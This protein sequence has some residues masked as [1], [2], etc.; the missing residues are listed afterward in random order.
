MFER[1]E[2]LFYV[3][4]IRRLNPVHGV[5][6]VSRRF[7][8]RY[9]VRDFGFCDLNSPDVSRRVRATRFVRMNVSGVVVQLNMEVIRRVVGGGGGT[10]LIQRGVEL[11][12]RLPFNVT[13]NSLVT[14]N[15]DRVREDAREEWKIAAAGYRNDHDYG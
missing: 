1:V 12:P 9:V 14:S 6:I 4:W 5:R 10:D 7:S 11:L 13:R 3:T 8:N 15:L 2:N